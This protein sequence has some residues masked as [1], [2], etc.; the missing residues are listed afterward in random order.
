ML[1]AAQEWFATSDVVIAA[2]AVADYRPAVR[3][4]GKPP[5]AAGSFSLEL[6][7]NPDIVASLAAQK[8][9]R[10]IVGFA[11]EASAAGLEAALR[12]GAAKLRQKQL[13]L[14][15][16]NLSSAIGGEASEAV[17]LFADGRR[18]E[19]PHQD[20]NATAARIVEAAVGLWQQRQAAKGCAT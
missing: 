16:V 14:V 18:L 1:A 15:V 9:R 17:L 4:T 13:D 11:L 3:Q 19:L 6:V 10:V 20:K 7:P 12:R 8:G 2:A 5:H